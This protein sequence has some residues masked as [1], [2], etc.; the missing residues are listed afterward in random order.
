MFL[1]TLKNGSFYTHSFDHSF[2]S[3]KEETT[4]ILFSFIQ[5]L[6]CVQADRRLNS[7][8]TT[9]AAETWTP[10]S[11]LPSCPCPSL[12][13]HCKLWSAVKSHQMMW[14]T[15]DE[16][17]RSPLISSCTGQRETERMQRVYQTDLQMLRKDVNGS[18][19]DECLTVS[20][21]FTPFLYANCCTP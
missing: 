15:K 17:R 21:M 3:F 5:Y 6:F 11:K 16:E 1:L 13:C 9:P 10:S 14:K 19:W 18:F 8:E 20:W 7:S 2:Y 4:Q 12:F